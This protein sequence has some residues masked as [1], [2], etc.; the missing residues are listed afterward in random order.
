MPVLPRHS[1]AQADRSH[2]ESPHA[3]ERT[4]VQVTATS[5]QTKALEFSRQSSLQWQRNLS[6]FTERRAM[7]L[8]NPV[9]H[10][11]FHQFVG[12][13]KQLILG[14]QAGMPCRPAFEACVAGQ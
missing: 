14:K 3:L 6:R 9:L 10:S 12:E 4:A 1:D 5:A 7:C 11:A 13:R 2:A 8:Q